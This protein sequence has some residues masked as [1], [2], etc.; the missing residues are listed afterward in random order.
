MGRLG[1][2][3][4]LGPIKSQLGGDN[5]PPT[6]GGGGGDLTI[7]SNIDGNILKSDGKA[8]E[9]SG[10]GS[11]R[12]ETSPAIHINSTTDLYVSG[13]G[14]NLFIQG[15]DQDGNMNVMYR[16]EISGGILKAVKT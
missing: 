7:N 8:D 13:S 14:N 15:A 1:G 2:R 3:R 5:S 11:L 4:T 9:I 12:Y 16:I 10:L 6:G